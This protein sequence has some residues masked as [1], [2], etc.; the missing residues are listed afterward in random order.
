MGGGA[1][2]TET[3]QRGNHARRQRTL[4]RAESAWDPSA[5]ETTESTPRATPGGSAGGPGTR[6]SSSPSPQPPPPLSIA[7]REVERPEHSRKRRGGLHG[8][9]NPQAEEAS[10]IALARTPRNTAAAGRNRVATLCFTA[11]VPGSYAANTKQQ[12]SLAF[13]SSWTLEPSSSP[14]HSPIS[15]A[16]ANATCKPRYADD[17]LNLHSPLLHCCFTSIALEGFGVGRTEED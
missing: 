2:V 11:F 5:A 12:T 13:V 17:G 4:A 14:T 9:G 1:A 8:L 16:E 7:S 3:G 6:S 10:R 15:T